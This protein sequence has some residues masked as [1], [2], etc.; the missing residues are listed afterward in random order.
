MPNY[1]LSIPS[2]LSVVRSS[3]RLSRSVGEAESPYTYAQQVY[4]NQGEQWQGEVQLR[5][6]KRSDAALIQSFLTQLQGKRGTFLYGDPDY[7]ALGPQGS[8]AGTPLVD[9]ASQTGDTLDVKGLTPSATDVYKAGDY[10]QLD[11]GANSE[12]YMVAAD[13]DAD[14]SGNATI[15]LCNNLKSSPADNEAVVLTGAKGVFRLVD[16]SVQWDADRSNIY[17]ISFAFK[18]AASV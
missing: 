12:L 15:T 13:V 9:G 2:N 7:L 17:N 11:T 6:Y 14:V 1:P 18:E 5:A 10:I 4:K 16:N 8:G 3:F